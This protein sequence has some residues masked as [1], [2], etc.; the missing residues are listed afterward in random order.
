VKEEV[1]VQVIVIEMTKHIRL[2]RR[3]RPDHWDGYPTDAPLCVFL[4]F[5]RSALSH[6]VQYA[7]A[8]GNLDQITE[9]TARYTHQL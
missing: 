1:Q 9:R 5:Q 8:V 4:D 2:L 3:R 7:E 6:H